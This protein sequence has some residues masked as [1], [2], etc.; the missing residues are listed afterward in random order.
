MHRPFPVPFSVAAASA[1]E[2]GRSNRKAKERY[3][4]RYVEQAVERPGIVG[5]WF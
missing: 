3:N 5:Q 2:I 1:E 4:N